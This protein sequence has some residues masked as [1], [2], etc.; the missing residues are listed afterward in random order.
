M[1]RMK[2]FI[3]DRLNILLEAVDT[4][5]STKDDYYRTLF[6][7]TKARELYSGD[8]YWENI[9][10]GD[11]VGSVI[12]NI[13]GQIQV[14]TNTA[15][16][17]DI[18]THRLGLV[19]EKPFY[20]IFQVR[21]GRGIEHPDTVKEP[22]YKARTRNGLG[23]EE[24]I[25]HYIFDLPQGVTL[26]N[27]DTRIEINLPKPGSPSSDAQIKSYLIYGE[28]IVSFVEKNLKNTIGYM[29]TKGAQISKEKMTPKQA[30]HKSKKDLEHE[31]NRRITDVEWN[32]YLKN[33][34][35]PNPKAVTSMDPNKAA[36]YEKKQADLQAKYAAMKAKRGM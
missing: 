32:E 29:D 24:N 30:T 23:S 22:E 35:K 27:G 5:Y 19:D 15:P 12:V 25:D 34:T 13:H 1:A 3:K 28:E 20:M 14:R 21:A 17:A 11:F 10:G 6:S 33:G 18:K 26:D 31:L 4:K 8:E 2:S 9:E 7:V 16:A 36:A